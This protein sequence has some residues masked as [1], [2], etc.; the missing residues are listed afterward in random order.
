MTLLLGAAGGGAGVFVV[1]AWPAALTATWVPAR[2]HTA[3]QHLPRQ[4]ALVFS[5]SKEMVLW[6]KALKASL[7]HSDHLCP[8]CAAHCLPAVLA[9]GQANV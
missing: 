5:I 8:G 9:P 1:A 6:W 3:C 2:L 4:R 7:L